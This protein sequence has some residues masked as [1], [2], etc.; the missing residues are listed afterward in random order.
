MCL[1]HAV[2]S[3]PQH[4]AGSSAVPGS[5]SAKESETTTYRLEDPVKKQ[6]HILPGCRWPAPQAAPAVFEPQRQQPEVRADRCRVVGQHGRVL[7]G[8]RQQPAVHD[9]RCCC[10]G[11][12]EAADDRPLLCQERKPE[13]VC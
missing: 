9:A 7:Q 6:Q 11:V 13:E 8:S 10:A 3:L 4:S 5:F 12:P 1:Q 2:E